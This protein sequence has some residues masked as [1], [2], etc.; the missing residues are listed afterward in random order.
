MGIIDD[1]NCFACSPE[2]E[3]G[4]KLRFQLNRTTQTATTTT[5]LKEHFSGW[6]DTA[7]GGI[8]CALLDESMVYACA[9]TDQLVVTGTISVKFRQPVPVGETLTIEGTLISHRRKTMTTVGRVFQNGE[10]LAEA[11]G[12]MIVVGEVLNPQAYNYIN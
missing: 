11:E 4:L 6:L 2:N 9:T 7:H 1:S 3:I 12:T 5:V 8:I 10:L